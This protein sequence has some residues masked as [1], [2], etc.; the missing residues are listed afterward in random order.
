MRTTYQGNI[1]SRRTFECIP[2][3]SR[4]WLEHRH[5]AVCLLVVLRNYRGHQA[6]HV[7][8]R[9]HR[10]WDTESLHGENDVV[11]RFTLRK[12]GGSKKSLDHIGNQLRCQLSICIVAFDHPPCLP[13][14][15]SSCRP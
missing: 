13:E 6:F 11:Q 3:N 14:A 10:K 5:E 2:K 12:I 9:I 15:V 1:R 8:P 4:F 7:V